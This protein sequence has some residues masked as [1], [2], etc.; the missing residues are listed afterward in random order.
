MIKHIFLGKGLCWLVIILDELKNSKAFE[1]S[2][3]SKAMIP[4]KYF[5]KILELKSL[6]L[7]LL[8]YNGVW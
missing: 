4:E 6:K 5:D 7:V 8:E 2:L 1:L 3:F